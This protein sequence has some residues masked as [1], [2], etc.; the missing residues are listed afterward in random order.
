MHTDRDAVD[1]HRCD[2]LV[3][4]DTRVTDSLVDRQ[5]SLEAPSTS[6]VGTIDVDG[7]TQHA[8][9]GGGI[10]QA[11]ALEAGVT[12]GCEIARGAGQGGANNGTWT[13]RLS[14]P[15]S[16]AVIAQAFVMALSTRPS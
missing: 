13:I 6:P 8:P 7:A 4:P 16:V 15:I 2:F 3:P 14:A 12:E 1:R 10:S 5:H 11:C 9:C